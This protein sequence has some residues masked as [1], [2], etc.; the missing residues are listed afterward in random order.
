MIFLLDEN[1]PLAAAALLHDQGH[2]SMDIRGSE[3]ERLTDVA[4]FDY[5]QKNQGILLTTDRDFFHTVPHLYSEHHGV[6]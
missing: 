5:A 1:I 2:E 3:L 6:I 4:L